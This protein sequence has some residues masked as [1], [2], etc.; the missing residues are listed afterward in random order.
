V[1]LSG[2]ILNKKTSNVS[3]KPSELKTAYHSNESILGELSSFRDIQSSVEKFHVRDIKPT[4][5]LITDGSLAPQDATDSTIMTSS[6]TSSHSS[7]HNGGVNSFDELFD[8][9]DEPSIGSGDGAATFTGNDTTSLKPQERSRSNSNSSAQSLGSFTNSPQHTSLQHLPP[10]LADLQN[11]NTF[12]LDASTPPNKKKITK[13]S[14]FNP[15]GGLQD[16]ASSESGDPL[17]SLDPLWT[18]SKHQSESS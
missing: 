5:D 2:G 4:E 14:F 6:I 9:S 13:A 18:I 16:S 8:L 15:S 1:V 11:P 10:S 3:K 12:T 17:S 7:A